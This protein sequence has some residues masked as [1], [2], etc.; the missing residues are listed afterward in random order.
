MTKRNHRQG[1]GPGKDTTDW[2]AERTLADAER[3]ALEQS[4]AATWN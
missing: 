1:S 2:S 4:S 3:D